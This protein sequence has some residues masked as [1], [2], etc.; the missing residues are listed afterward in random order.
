MSEE[1]A[2]Q[3]EPKV[4]PCI[5]QPALLW[6]CTPDKGGCGQRG[7][8][9]Q[10]EAIEHWAKGGI[11]QLACQCGATVTIGKP[12]GPRIITPND[13]RGKRMKVVRSPRC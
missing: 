5:G 12:E 3:D 2:K 8:I 1:Q 7:V 11:G 6:E 13:L 10:L 4:V 9:P